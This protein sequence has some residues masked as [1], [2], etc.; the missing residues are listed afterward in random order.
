MREDMY[1]AAPDDC[2]RGRS[3]GL[4]PY[5]ALAAG[6]IVIAVGHFAARF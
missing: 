3:A 6:V 1:L 5:I 4:L 2:E